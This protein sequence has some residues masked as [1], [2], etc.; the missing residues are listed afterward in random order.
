[1]FE[2]FELLLKQADIDIKERKI[3][4]PESVSDAVR[5]RGLEYVMEERDRAWRK[6]ADIRKILDNDGEE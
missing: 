2:L 3:P 1:M 6:L 4:E 5:I